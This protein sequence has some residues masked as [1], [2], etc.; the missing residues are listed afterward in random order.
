MN[1]IN[2]QLELDTI[3]K[4]I[5]N[6]E[7]GILSQIIRKLLMADYEIFGQINQIGQQLATISDDVQKIIDSLKEEDELEDADDS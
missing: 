4:A 6:G 5:E 2:I 7:K 1:E 3:L